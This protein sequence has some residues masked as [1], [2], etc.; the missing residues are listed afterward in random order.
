MGVG[1]FAGRF[2]MR[3]VRFPWVRLRGHRPLTV[4]MDT[5]NRCNLRCSMCPMR[6]SDSDSTRNWHDMDPDLFDRIG[7]EVFP[8][9][10]TVALSCG[11]EPLVNPDFPRFLE[12]LHRYDVPVRELVT[13]GILLGEGMVEN[14][15]RTPPTSLF[16]SID[17]ARPETHAAIRGGADLELVL[18]NIRRLVKSRDIRGSRFP[19]VSFSVTL[20]KR[21]IHE[22]PDIVRMAADVGA[23]S[24]NTVLLVPY[25]GLEMAGQ[26][27]VPGSPEVLG[28]L[29]AAG[30][31]AS[32]LGIIFVAPRV[33][34]GLPDPFAGCPYVDSWV[35]ID[36]DGKVNPC[37]YWNVSE[38]LGD[39]TL[40]SFDDVWGSP[41]YTALRQRTSRGVLSGNCSICPEVSPVSGDEIDK[42]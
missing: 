28:M 22:L 20:Q 4:R 10:S 16:V 26:V 35:F 29:E 11:A 3:S 27:L 7:C 30:S 39:L 13:N 17:G 33:E 15:L 21:N 5:T 32:A 18:S 25:S 12:I 9:A 31:T 19:M 41:A 36:P 14:I 24:V 40:D 37:P 8:R 2:L 23:T 1:R 6:L 38:P 34:A 42:I